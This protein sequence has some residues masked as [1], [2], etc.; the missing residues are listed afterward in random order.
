MPE[1]SAT[2]RA[3]YLTLKPG[4]GPRP[5][6][7]TRRSKQACSPARTRSTGV[8]TVKTVPPC[9][10]PVPHRV[11]QAAIR[12][13]PAWLAVVA[14]PAAVVGAMT[15]AIAMSAVASLFTQIAPLQR[16]CQAIRWDLAFSGFAGARRV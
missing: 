13:A 3:T 12:T 1:A 8:D 11:E 16:R 5:M 7:T 10:G 9:L 2:I 6:S 4:R 14:A 15:A